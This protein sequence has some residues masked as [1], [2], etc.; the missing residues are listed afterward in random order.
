MNATGKRIA[1]F[2]EDMYEDQEFW[3]PYFR[4]LEAGAKVTVVGTTKKEFKSKH[5]YPAAADV[6]IDDVSAAAFDGVIIPGGYAPDK[7]RRY[8]KLLEFVREI[9]RAGKLVATICHGGWVLCSTKTLR[10][11]T[12]TGVSAIKDDLTNAGATYV[13]AEVVRDGHLITSRTP[14]DLP[15]FLRTILQ[16]LAESPGDGKARG[17]NAGKPKSASAGSR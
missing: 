7:M 8:P 4:L 12:V 1:I 2:V 9:D 3:Y 13:D 6:G 14:K 16:T 11:R 5:G 15:A 17:G 10:G